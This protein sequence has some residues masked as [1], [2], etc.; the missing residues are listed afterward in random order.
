MSFIEPNPKLVHEGL[1]F[2]P[3]SSAMHST[4][5]YLLFKV[6]NCLKVEPSYNDASSKVVK[7][8]SKN[9]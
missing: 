7:Y 5:C 6:V 1:L 2:N 8:L 9:L 4:I 3:T